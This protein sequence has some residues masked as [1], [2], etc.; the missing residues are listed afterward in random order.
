MRYRIRFIAATTSLMGLI[1]ACSDQPASLGPDAAELTR[2][3][4]ASVTPTPTGF[5][6]TV[7]PTKNETFVYM[8]QHKIVFPA[9]SICDPAT[10]SYGPAEWDA[11]CEPLTTPITITADTMSING[12]PY[13]KF[14]PAL[15]FVP[16]ADPKQW[17]MLYMKDASAS[18]PL[19]GPT[20]TIL[21]EAPDGSFVDETL[22]DPTL[23]TQV[24]GSSSIV[25]RRLKHFSGYLVATR[26]EVEIELQ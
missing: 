5:T 9:N 7:N 11:P 23:A 26:A 12:H 1:V 17:V 10:S 16:T 24:Q 25:Y 21:W 3:S 15:R 4:L 13:I 8:G 22:S 18:D 14:S 20:L 6:F 19:V 2:P